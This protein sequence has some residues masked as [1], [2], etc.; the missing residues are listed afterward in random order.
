VISASEPA[1]EKAVV[2]DRTAAGSRGASESATREAETLLRTGRPY[3]ARAWL[4]GKLADA[5]KRRDRPVVRRATLLLGAAELALG[6]LDAAGDSLGR[7]FEMGVQDGD[8]L[9]VADATYH[10]GT[11]ARVQGRYDEALESF[12]V[13]IPTYQRLAEPEGLSRTFHEMASTFRDLGE[14]ARAEEY[15]RWAADYA[16]EAGSALL[17]TLTRLARAE[18]ALRAG[19]AATAESTARAVAAAFERLDDPIGRADALRVAGA[20]CAGLGRHDAARAALDT[21]LTLA[22]RHGSALGEAET[23]RA[24]AEL[25]AAEGDFA[26]MRRRAEGAFAGFARLGAREEARRLVVW[27][28]E[29]AGRA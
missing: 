25:A 12:Q 26:E 7:A 20:A 3:D 18:L 28:T 17:Q 10:L 1:V 8:R 15:E 4:E 29:R 16:E 2:R 23:L 19:E 11:I 14:L 9:T 6:R 13:A 22:R 21:A 24:L 5:V 27:V